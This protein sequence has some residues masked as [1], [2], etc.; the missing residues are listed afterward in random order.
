MGP[1]WEAE[2]VGGSPAHTYSRGGWDW[3][4]LEVPSNLSHSMVR[5]C[6]D[7]FNSVLCFGC[8]IH[9]NFE[10]TNIMSNVSGLNYLETSCTVNHTLGSFL[11]SFTVM[12]IS[13]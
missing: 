10:P 11:F 3:M 4:V 13:F 12:V 8:V 5:F 7:N 9:T 6:D 2:L 1:I